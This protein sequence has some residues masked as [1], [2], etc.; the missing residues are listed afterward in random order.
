LLDEFALRLNEKLRDSDVI[1]RIEE[2]SLLLL[3]PF[4]DPEGLKARIEQI[5]QQMASEE[6]DI[7]DLRLVMHNRE[8]LK[9]TGSRDIQSGLGLMQSMVGQAHK[10]TLK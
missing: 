8:V 5:F 7:K 4:T 9:S 10:A 3:L 2:N 6:G 1:T